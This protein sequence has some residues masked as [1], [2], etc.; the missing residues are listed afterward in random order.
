M[1]NF[2]QTG[3]PSDPTEDM[4]V[5]HLGHLSDA[6]YEAVL[7]SVIAFMNARWPN[8]SLMGIDS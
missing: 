2:G 7:Q 8:I 1:E 4:I 6:Q 5:L 3:A